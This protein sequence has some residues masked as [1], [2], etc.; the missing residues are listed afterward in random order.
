MSV[1][2]QLCMC[3]ES[4]EISMLVF[5][6][7]EILDSENAANEKKFLLCLLD[8]LHQRDSFE[9][10]TGMWVEP[11]KSTSTSIKNLV[12]ELIFD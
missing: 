7:C 11:V 9:L 10:F 4:F 12:E 3:S 5:S 6:T 8:V 1:L 2:F